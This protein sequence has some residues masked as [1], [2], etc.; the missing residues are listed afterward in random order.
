MIDQKLDPD[1]EP[2]IWLYRSKEQR[3]SK[4]GGLPNLPWWISWPRRKG[5]I[6][7]MAD[8]IAT[9]GYSERTTLLLAKVM[10]PFENAARRKVRPPMHF[11]GQIDLAELPTLPLE[12]GGPTLPTSGFLFFFATLVPNEASDDIFGGHY[13]MESEH[14][15]GAETQVIYA[16]S[17]GPE[18]NA[19]KG[20]PPLVASYQT[21][22]YPTDDPIWGGVFPA[23][24][25]S[26]KRIW[27]GGVDPMSGIILQSELLP[28]SLLYRDWLASR[29]D[30]EIPV[31]S[32]DWQDWA[33]HPV[34]LKEYRQVINGNEQVTSRDLHWVRHQMFGVAPTVQ[35]EPGSTRHMRDRDGNSAIMLMTF[36]TDWG[37]HHEFMFCDCGVLQFWI[38]PEDLAARRFDRCYATTEGG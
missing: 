24:S 20:L 6:E 27:T 22:D 23:H 28:R 21:R 34:A 38:K 1:A 3:R 33:Q 12:P 19:P 37:V 15:Y 8:E 9:L 29:L 16:R 32:I 30:V 36:D 7:Q 13:W 2:A 26:A 4:F 5:T 18:R 25:M 35:Y 31:A 10:T 17:A 14:D 11:L